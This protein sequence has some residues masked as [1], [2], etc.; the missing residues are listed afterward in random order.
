MVIVPYENFTKLVFF[1]LIDGWTADFRNESLKSN[2]I[3]ANHLNVPFVRHNN[4]CDDYG[5]G[6][7]SPVQ[8]NPMARSK[9]AVFSAPFE[10][11]KKKDVFLSH[12]ATEPFLLSIFITMSDD[13]TKSQ[14]RIWDCNKFHFLPNLSVSNSCWLTMLVGILCDV[15]PSRGL[16]W[17]RDSM[18]STGNGGSR[19]KV[20]RNLHIV[21]HQV[22]H[23][24]RYVKEI[25]WLH[26]KSNLSIKGRSQ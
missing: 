8:S 9:Q 18:D 15:S 11:E 19:S 23:L 3:W 16:R 7:H 24:L 26:C 12:I 1:I 2:S 21:R 6:Y 20:L 17:E 13:K 14:Q 5:N 25:V 10:K 4:Y 22:P